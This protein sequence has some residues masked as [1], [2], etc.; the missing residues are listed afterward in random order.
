MA[1][2]LQKWQQ[3]FQSL[4]NKIEKLQNE[5]KSLEKFK[6]NAGDLMKS[7]NQEISNLR[8]KLEKEQ[9]TILSLKGK[10]SNITWCNQQLFD[11]NNKYEETL[12]DLKDKLHQN[13]KEL[14]IIKKDYK[15]IQ[16]T[17]ANAE[18][19]LKDDG[20][21][22]GINKQLRTQNK[23]LQDKLYKRDSNLISKLEH[24]E[25]IK[26]KNEKINELYGIID[27]LRK[28]SESECFIVSLEPN[29]KRRRR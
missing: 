28:E 1:T 8:S 13:E 20:M 3:L 29:K 4:K 25:L 15:S 24:N 6:K 23:E 17:L 14:N 27:D 16:S 12:D 21:Q 9:F 18:K 11:Q 26:I 19:K 2:P 22:K 10:V 7:K 5:N